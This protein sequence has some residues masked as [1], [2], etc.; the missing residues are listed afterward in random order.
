MRS[1][2]QQVILTQV[3]CVGLSY[4][5]LAGGRSSADSDR[6]Q[7]ILNGIQ[8]R[9]ARIWSYQCTQVA[10]SPN[11]HSPAPD[12]LARL[13]FDARGRGLVKTTRGLSSDSY[14][15]DGERTLEL[16]ERT[17]PDGAVVYSVRVSRGIDY[18]AQARTVPWVYLG[19]ELLE[20]LRKAL[21]EGRPIHTQDLADGTCRI[22]VHYPS[23]GVVAAVLHP[24]LGYSPLVQE[25]YI[26]GQLRKREEVKFDN[27]DPGAWFPVAV[28]TT[29]YSGLDPNTGRPRPGRTF[30]QRFVDIVINDPG[31]EKV[32]A[33]QLPEGTEVYDKVR[34]V[35][36]IVGQKS[37]LSLRSPDAGTG[38]DGPGESGRKAATGRTD[39][40]GRGA[41]EAVYRLDEKESLKRIAPPFIPQRGPYL[42]REKLDLAS[43]SEDAPQSTICLFQWD[44]QLRRKAFLAGS[45]FL[46]LSLILEAVCG[47]DSYEYDGPNALLELQLPGDW[48]VRQGATKEELLHDLQG[49][50]E[51]ET[52]R[53]IIFAEDEIE[54][55]VIRAAGQYRRARADADGDRLRVLAGDSGTARSQPDGGGAGRMADFLAELANRIGM[56]VIDDTLSSSIQLQ[57]TH[58]K[59][60]R[61]RDLRGD[62]D[63]YA[64]QLAALVNS[65]AQQTGLT[66][67]IETGAVRQWQVTAPPKAAI[68]SRWSSPRR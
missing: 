13:A 28:K 68:I 22:E 31:F 43:G 36:Y 10:A 50:I 23:G 16:R 33:P 46:P 32:L 9:L 34:G 8:A 56:P 62:P 58:D 63:L 67:T 27:I 12:S 53:P 15:W 54:C 7:P 66:F 30:E 24:G 6:V 4:P 52:G 19:G 20:V 65:L 25:T 47:L 60:S 42:V 14:V 40:G 45:G 11:S 49:I 55:R 29:S 21:A 41:F 57:W 51:D 37:V 61:L 2:I 1:L 35:H 17:K 48:I 3:V 5:A 59:S 18:Q 64:R 38:D 26:G 39:D 44:G